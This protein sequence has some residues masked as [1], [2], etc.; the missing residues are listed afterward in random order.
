[1]ISI[2]INGYVVTSNQEPTAEEKECIELAIVYAMNE[3]WEECELIDCSCDEWAKND[4]QAH[5]DNKTKE[6]SIKHEKT[7]FMTIEP[8]DEW[9][10]IVEEDTLY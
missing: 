4:I 9:L 6:L 3:H 2:Q 1:M 7:K 8:I 10:K 5:F